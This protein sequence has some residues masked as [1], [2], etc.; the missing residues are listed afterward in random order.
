MTDNWLF[1]A[2][3]LFAWAWSM[4]L[5]AS[6]VGKWTNKNVVSLNEEKKDPAAFLKKKLT[7]P[8]GVGQTDQKIEDSKITFVSLTQDRPDL[9]FHLGEW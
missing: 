1:P 5:G 4:S 9:V 8:T 3:N 6:L 2:Y 7:K